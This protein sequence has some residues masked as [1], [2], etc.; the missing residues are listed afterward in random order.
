MGYEW[1]GFLIVLL[2]GLFLIMGPIATFFPRKVAQLLGAGMVMRGF[3]SLIRYTVIYQLYGHGDA[4]QYFKAGLY[5][6]DLI[7]QYDF[8]FFH[9]PLWGGN[10]WGTQMVMFISGF[11]IALIGPTQKGEFLFFAILSLIGL[12]LFAKAFQRNYPQ[13][14]LKGYLK[15]LL[16]WP[17]LWFWPSSVGKDALML[18]STAL[19]VYGY[20][21]KK[22]G[23]ISWI[24][25][26]MSF[27]L[28]AV[29]RPHVAGVMV[30]SLAI[31]H[32]LSP[33]RK[34]GSVHIWQGLLI[35]LLLALVLRQGFSDLGL[36]QVDVESLRDYV[37]LQAK[38]SAEGGSAISA[39]G[40]TLTAI[41]IGVVNVL[42]R[43]FPWEAGSPLLAAASLEMVVFWAIFFKRRHRIFLVMKEWRSNRLLCL[44]VP[45]T[46]LYVVMLGL[47]MGNLGIIARQRIHILPML[48]VW[49]EARPMAVPVYESRRYMPPALTKKIAT[50]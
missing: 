26:G 9:G 25:L 16:F 19:L 12:L 20:T 6:S 24:I 36:D 8:S 48:F 22:E 46:I 45:L 32:W 5:Y 17:S 34:W 28:A 39:G 38:R 43:P 14:D 7:W 23:K 15:W 31:A 1:V 21:A 2:S 47:A 35:L 10:W 30:V 42:F 18:L 29:I 27:V 50:T 40:G 3:G 13:S 33:S 37:D 41:P 49:L 11:V 44:I 4:E